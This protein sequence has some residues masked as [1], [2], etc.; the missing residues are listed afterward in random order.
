MLKSFLQQHRYRV[1]ASLDNAAGLG[2]LQRRAND[3]GAIIVGLGR[4]GAG[5]SQTMTAVR[6]IAPSVP[7]VICAHTMDHCDAPADPGCICIGKPLDPA[8]LLA[9]LR[10]VLDATAG[11][12]AS[13]P[14]AAPFS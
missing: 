5:A 3:I 12:G 10:R 11:R 7:L 2:E 6:A 8:E 4:A 14:R 9:A 1:L 13:A